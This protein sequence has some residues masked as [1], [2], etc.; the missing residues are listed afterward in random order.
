MTEVISLP[1]LQKRLSELK[2]AGMKNTL[3]IRLK[4][5]EG[6]SMPLSS[7]PFF[8]QTLQSFFFNIV[9]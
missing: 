7:T 8:E 2:L 6:D 3:E 9:I 4:Q 5:A 1:I